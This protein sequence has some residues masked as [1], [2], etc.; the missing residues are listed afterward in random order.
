[1]DVAEDSWGVVANTGILAGEILT[2]FGGTTY[3]LGSTQVGKE[4]SE[5]QAKMVVEGM[6]LQYTFQGHLAEAIRSRY[7]QSRS[8]T[9]NQCVQGQMSRSGCDERSARKVIKE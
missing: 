7:G 6:P 8:R 4:F 2:V 9:R 1:M 3:I 5:I